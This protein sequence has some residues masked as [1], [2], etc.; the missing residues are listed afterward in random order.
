MRQSSTQLEGDF[1]KKMRKCVSTSVPVPYSDTRTSGSFK[2]TDSPF[3]K[4]TVY[5]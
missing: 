2:M 4:R 3:D 1:K 5:S